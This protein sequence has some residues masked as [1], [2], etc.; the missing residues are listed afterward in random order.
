SSFGFGGTN[1]H[2][3]LSSAAPASTGRPARACDTL[4]L[5]AQ[6]KASLAELA[7]ESADRLAAGADPEKYAGAVADARPLMRQRAVLPVGQAE[8]MANDL[9]A[10]ASGKPAPAVQTGSSLASAPQVCFVY[11]GNG[12]QW[13]GMG[14]AAYKTNRV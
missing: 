11:N 3:I 12:S 5:S 13:V 2:V 10:F 6:C 4:I 14:R 8:E 9:R 7:R 1:A